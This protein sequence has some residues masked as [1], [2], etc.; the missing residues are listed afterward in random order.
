MGHHQ[1]LLLKLSH[2]NF[3][4]ICSFRCAYLFI[5]LMPRLTLFPFSTSPFLIFT[6]LKILKLCVHYKIFLKTLFLFKLPQLFLLGVLHSSSFVVCLLYHLVLLF[7]SSVICKHLYYF[8]FL[9]CGLLRCNAV[10]CLLLLHWLVD[11]PNLKMGTI[12]SSE[13]SVGFY[14]TEL[15]KIILFTVVNVTISG[16]NSSSIAVVVYSNTIL[17]GLL[18]RASVRLCRWVS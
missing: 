10:I 16:G 14:R 15:S 11:S 4:I 13:T 7:V 18:P 8:I 2:C 3:Y 1:V 5:C 9:V 12:C 17:H 6:I